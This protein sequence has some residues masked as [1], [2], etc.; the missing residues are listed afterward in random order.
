MLAGDDATGAMGIRRRM[1][2]IRPHMA[3]IILRL[4]IRRPRIQRTPTMRRIGIT[5]HTTLPIIDSREP[6][7]GGAPLR[8]SPPILGSPYVDP[9]ASEI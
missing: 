9:V 2:I 1:R 4:R 6:C 3:T 7:A 5:D 8:L